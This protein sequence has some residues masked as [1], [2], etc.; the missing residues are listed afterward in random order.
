MIAEKDEL[1]ERLEAR[2]AATVQQMRQFN[3]EKDLHISSLAKD[4]VVMEN[5]LQQYR[6]E[7]EKFVDQI[8][9]MEKRLDRQVAI[10]QRIEEELQEKIF[11]LEDNLKKT[12]LE[13]SALRGENAA[14]E[15]E[16]DEVCSQLHKVKVV[17][18]HRGKLIYGRKGSNLLAKPGSAQ[19]A[20]R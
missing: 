13:V 5:H 2:I 4:K 18:K 6:N 10:D 11:E 8:A 9:M 17:N 3:S 16:N 20:F 14:L 12:R 7:Q 19:L 1:S 15:T